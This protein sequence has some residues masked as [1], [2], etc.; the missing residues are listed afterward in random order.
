MGLLAVFMLHVLRTE[1][2][3]M[4]NN[5]NPLMATSAN[6]AEGSMLAKLESKVQADE[7]MLAT[8]N[9]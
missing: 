7:A 6:G 3:D 9:E 4:A 8:H 2:R 1:I 5:S